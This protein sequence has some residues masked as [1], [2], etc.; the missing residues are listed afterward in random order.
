MSELRGITWRHTRGFLPM[1]ATAQRFSELYPD[2]NIR[3]ETRSLQSFADQSIAQLAEVFDLLVIDHPYAGR[4]ARGDVLLPL[5]E[6]L[7]AEFVTEQEKNAVGQ[8]YDSYRYGGHLWALPTDTA[9]P[10]SGARIDLL[11]RQHL[12]I[13]KTWSE[14]LALARRGM[15]VV[16]AIPIDSLMH[17]YMLCIGL[18]E[19]PF[20]NRSAI[21]SDRTGRQAL[22]ML[23]ELI[24]LCDPKCLSRNPIAIWELM[25]ST[26]EAVY[27]PFAYGYSN[28]ARPRYAKNTIEFGGLI[29]IDGHNACR[30]TLGGAGLSIS[31][32]TTEPELAAQYAAFVASSE[33]QKGIYFE[34]G[35]QPGHRSAWTDDV[36]NLQSG[37]FFR[38]T[39]RT[40]DEAYMRPRF[41]VYPAFQDEA[42]ELVHTYLSRGGDSG[43]V[44]D[45]LNALLRLIRSRSLEANP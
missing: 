43:V 7:E 45:E 28:Y 15:V 23:R 14:L 10:V 34:S 6:L 27:C 35:G 41:D 20:Q 25:S 24:L 31:R 8:S 44:L 11:T 9:T 3:W 17:F 26:D 42:G 40:L 2:V 18:G 5:D 1:V 21:V 39:L 16:P 38:K 12:T 22:E 29:A 30:S 4:A 37:G 33:V 32:C 13:P 19:E 36:V